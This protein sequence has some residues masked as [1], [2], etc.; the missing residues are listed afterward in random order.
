MAR[1]VF[2]PSLSVLLALLASTAFP[3]LAQDSGGVCTKIAASFK[4]LAA[5]PSTSADAKF[6]PDSPLTLLGNQT[7]SGVSVGAHIAE[8]GKAQRPLEWAQQQ[9]L[10]LPNDLKDALDKAD[11]VDQLPDTNF[12]AASR[13]EGTAYCYDTTT[14]AVAGN[15]AQ[16][17]PAPPNWVTNQ[18]FGSGC[19]VFR[20]FGKVDATS[21]AFEEM[22][23]YSPALTATLTASAWNMD[24]F[25]PACTVTFNFEP[26][27]SPHDTYNDWEQI[28][29][30]TNCDELRQLAL[31]LIERV[32]LDPVA[33]EKQLVENLSDDQRADF[34]ALE[35][36]AQV[37]QPDKIPG[38]ADLT[39]ASP[40]AVPLLVG[41]EVYLAR[42]GHF[43]IG[44]RTYSDWSVRLDKR[45]GDDVQAI[46]VI[47]IGMTKGKLESADVK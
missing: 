30:A 2:F 15:S 4:Q 3:A 16:T 42:V 46:G 45:K 37:T 28:C 26:R 14:F 35:K 5:N 13:I 10:Q 47:A 38:P 41:D 11:F 9:G 20:A 21:A 31:T 6:Y 43:T 39:D 22:Y 32:Q 7:D 1:L 25:D 19:G 8:T 34:E 44:W 12:Y 27:F 17:A 29:T 18:D 33:A 36:L 24:H 23:D 40:L